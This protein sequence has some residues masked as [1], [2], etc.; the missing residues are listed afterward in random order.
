[1]FEVYMKMFKNRLEKVCGRNWHQVSRTEN[2][3]TV[4][5]NRKFLDEL[6][7]KM[8]IINAIDQIPAVNIL[9]P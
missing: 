4:R 7:G 6:P 5:H 1:M 9:I 8:Y 2:Y 3:L